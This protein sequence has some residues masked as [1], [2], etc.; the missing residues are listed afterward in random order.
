MDDVLLRDEAAPFALILYFLRVLGD[1][2]EG[3]F[4]LL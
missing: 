1:G 4:A 3:I 2:D